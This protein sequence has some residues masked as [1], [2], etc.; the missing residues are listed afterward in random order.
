M[1]RATI[2]SKSGAVITIEGSE[3]EIANI[4][5]AFEQAERAGKVR[6]RVSKMK[7]ERKENKKRQ[8]ASELLIGLK[9]EGFFEKPKA[10]GDITQALEEKGYLYPVTSLSGVV[11]S[12]VK[13]HHLRR[14]KVEGRW[15]YGK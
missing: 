15:V 1:P 2:K 6:Q 4:V 9:E 11:L 10:L 5:S 13:N 12:L 14:K 7:M 8:S 3:R